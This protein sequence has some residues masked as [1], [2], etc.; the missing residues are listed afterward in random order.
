[1]PPAPPQP[2]GAPRQHRA[3]TREAGGMD[4]EGRPQRGRAEQISAPTPRPHYSTT[5]PGHDDGP[6]KTVR[7][8]DCPRRPRR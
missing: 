8:Y 1:P 4:E 7:Y 6:T 2:T 3:K 5:P